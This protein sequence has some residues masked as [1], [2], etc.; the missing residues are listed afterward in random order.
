MSGSRVALGISQQRQLLISL[1][2]VLASYTGALISRQNL[3][4]ALGKHYIWLS[5]F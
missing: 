2:D 1:Y 4:P 3:S 5:K